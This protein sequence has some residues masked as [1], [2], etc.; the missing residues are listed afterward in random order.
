MAVTITSNKKNTSAVIHISAANSGN[1]VV[2][3]NSTTT[4]V[5]ATATCLA[6]SDEVLSGAYIAQIFWGCD[7]NGH[8]Q[9]LRGT[10]LVGVYD[11]TGYCDYAGNGM[12]LNVSPAANLVVN[13]VGSANSYCL[14]EVQKQGTFISPYNNS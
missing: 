5:G 3:G 12:P 8:I 2:V 6:T 13:F 9:I 11:S 7:G 1:I 10:T 14:L 4:N